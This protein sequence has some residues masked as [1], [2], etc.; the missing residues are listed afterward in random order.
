MASR[1]TFCMGLN[2]SKKYVALSLTLFFSADSERSAQ[3]RNSSLGVK[4]PAQNGKNRIDRVKFTIYQ[5]YPFFTVSSLIV[6]SWRVTL[7]GGLELY[8][9]AYMILKQCS[10]HWDSQKFRFNHYVKSLQRPAIRMSLIEIL[11]KVSDHRDL[12]IYFCKDIFIHIPR[13]S[14]SVRP[15]L[16]DDFGP[17][18][19]TT[20]PRPTSSSVSRPANLGSNAERQCS[21]SGE[22]K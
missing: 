1:H 10:T 14:S 4:M 11:K 20:E 13:T 18:W 7:R 5:F 2:C 12:C 19:R 3:C 8:L 17:D 21:S 15:L 6:S 22:E 16:A 9:Y